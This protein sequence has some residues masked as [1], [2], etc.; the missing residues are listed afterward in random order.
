MSSL[1]SL[2][3]GV[4]EERFVIAPV[5]RFFSSVC[6]RVSFLRC[7]DVFCVMLCQCVCV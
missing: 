3:V 6:L 5:V 4:Y 7:F 2:G 1:C